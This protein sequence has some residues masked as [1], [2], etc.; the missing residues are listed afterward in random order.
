[1]QPILVKPSHA[2]AIMFVLFNKPASTD[3]MTSKQIVAFMERTSVEGHGLLQEYVGD[4]RPTQPQTDHGV[5]M[6]VKRGSVSKEDSNP[7]QRMK[8]LT[9]YAQRVGSLL[10]GWRQDN[11][12]IEDRKEKGSVKFSISPEFKRALAA[13]FGHIQFSQV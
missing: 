2:R 13:E 12:L 8:Q 5:E 9:L 4:E 1:M 7:K 3:F 10:F 6:V 11:G